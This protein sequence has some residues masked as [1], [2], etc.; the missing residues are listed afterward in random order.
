MIVLLYDPVHG[1]IMP[2]RIFNNNKDE[3]YDYVAKHIKDAR[4]RQKQN[5]G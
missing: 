4:E 1:Q 2:D 5:N 3:F